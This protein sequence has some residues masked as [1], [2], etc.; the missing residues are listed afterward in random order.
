MNT[1]SRRE[2]NRMLGNRDINKLNSKVE[3][4]GVKIR[5]NRDI[6]KRQRLWKLQ[7]IINLERESCG[8]EKW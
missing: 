5:F 4:L 7:N 3:E 8:E 6:K 1:F 2:L